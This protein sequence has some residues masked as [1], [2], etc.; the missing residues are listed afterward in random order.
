MSQP[1]ALI[2]LIS[3]QTMQNLLPILRLKPARVVHLATPKTAARS[4]HIVEAARQAQVTV[5]PENQLLSRMPGMAETFAAVKTAILQCRQAGETPIVNFT[6][7]TKLM[8]IGAFS[9][10]LNQNHRAMSLYVDTEDEVF[11]DGRT[12]DGLADLLEGDFSFTALHRCLTVNAVAVA[13]GRERVTGGRD[14]KPF[15]PLAE[16]FR[17]HPAEEQATHDAIFGKAGLLPRGQTPTSPEEWLQLLDRSFGLP[18]EV[19]GL[20][21]DAGL[22]RL[23]PDGTCRLPDTSKAELQ[24]LADARAGKAYVHDYDRR[25]IAATES[26]QFPITFLAGGWWEVVVADAGERSGLFRDLRWSASAGQR[27]GS[28]LEEDILAVDGVQ[29]VCISCKRGGAKARLLPQLEE[30]NARA[31]SLGGNFTRRFLA[32]FLPLGKRPGAL[33]P[34]RAAE[35]DVKIL[36]PADLN[37]ADAFA[38]THATA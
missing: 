19:V 3:E 15:L 31:R 6:G 18:G 29:A 10:A 1:L 30:L 20:A 24:E 35:L 26:V 38:R 27:A 16:Y 28:D 33:L 32:V 17:D 34:Q 13:N 21:A 8:S 7:G 9:A 12:A 25:R 5:K 36:T 22:V 11:L 14:W 37:R 4:A 2:Q 23:A